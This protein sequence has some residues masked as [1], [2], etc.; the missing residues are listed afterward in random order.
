M[1]GILQKLFGVA[2]LGLCAGCGGQGGRGPV[3]GWEETL[4]PMTNLERVARLDLPGTR[5]ETSFDPTGGNDDFNHYLRKGPAGWWVVADLK[6]PGVLTRFWTTGATAEGAHRLRMYFDGEKE[7]RIDASLAEYFGPRDQYCWVSYQPIPFRRQ[8]VVMLQEGATRSDG[9]PRLFF[10]I[11]H[12]PLAAGAVTESLP[13]KLGAEDRQFLARLRQGW[14]RRAE[15]VATA[16]ERKPFELIATPGQRV[17]CE[18]AQGPALVTELRITPRWDAIASPVLREQA[19]RNVILRMEWDGAAESSVAVPLGD[20]FGSLWRRRHFTSA[21]VGMK[22]DT[23]ECRFPMPYRVQARIGVENQGAQALPLVIEV[24]QRPLAGELGREWGY[25]HAAWQKSGPEQRGKPHTVLHGL[26]SG[27]FAGCFLSATSLDGSWWLLEGDESIRVDKETVPGWRG[28]G[29]EDYFNGG[30]YYQNPSARP[31]YG[32]LERVAYRTIQYRFHLNDAV[33]FTE[34]VDVQFER[35]PDNASR[36]WMESVAYY[37]LAQPAAAAS[38]LGTLKDREPPPDPLAKATLMSEVVNHERLQDFQGARELI[39]SWI[40]RNAGGTGEATLRLRQIACDEQRLGFDAVK[41]RY[42]E[43]AAGCT[44]AA[45]LAQCKQILWYH[46]APDRALLGLFSNGRT[47]VAIDGTPIVTA[48]DPA[49]L[50][51]RTVV[52]PPGRH[53]LTAESRWTRQMPWV[54][55]CLRTHRG[56]IVTSPE[57]KWT[58]KAAAGWQRVDFDDRAWQPYGKSGT[59]GPPEE[60]YAGQAPDGYAGMQAGATGIRVDD[61]DKYRDTACLR[62]VFTVK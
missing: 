33:R 36:G 55:V 41:A 37:Y 11:N 26:G 60:P 1:T 28:T 34:S 21:F 57:W 16:G 61:W 52:L 24:V 19:L 22:G 45:A 7:P 35:G 32:L 40:E 6:G 10:Q 3:T 8:L 13:A 50:V 59:K 4:L 27:K 14:E 62:Y 15:D 31:L 23:F 29:L 25:F 43:F 12:S 47:T 48:D 2:I 18:L 44:D 49:H 17:F 56:D 9:W 54:Q 51:V 53:V 5:I 39:D 42:A 38:E 20:F 30:W 58:R 46:E